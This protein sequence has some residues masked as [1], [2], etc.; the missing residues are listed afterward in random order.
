M[1]GSKFDLDKVKQLVRDCME[2]KD[3]VW[4]SAPS[5]SVDYLIHIFECT[6]VEAG[7][8]ILN[9]LLKLETRDFSRRVSMW[10]RIA[11]QYGLESYLGHNW[12]IKFMLEDGELEQISFHPCENNMLLE[13]GRVITA[14][15]G[16]NDMPSWRKT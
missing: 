5:C 6:Q 15:I 16:S 9:G 11:D 8:I 13:N 7:S 12:Y 14:S 4:F 10:S 1:Q 3:C 2:G